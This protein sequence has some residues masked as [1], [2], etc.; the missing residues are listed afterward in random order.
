M[1]T[2]ILA[3]ISRKITC[4]L[5]VPCE[6]GWKNGACYFSDQNTV[7]SLIF[8]GILF[9]VFVILCLCNSLSFAFLEGLYRKPTAGVCSD[10][11]KMRIHRLRVYS[12]FC[13]N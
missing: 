9:R 3:H 13:Y 2:A 5:K 4:V 6:A 7:K 12:F 8:P 11:A 1:V 10:P